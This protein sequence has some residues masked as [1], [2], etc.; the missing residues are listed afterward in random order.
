[1]LA[2]AVSWDMIDRNPFEKAESLQLTENN[3]RLSY[4]SEK[5]IR[6]LLLNARQRP[7]RQ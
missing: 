3:R 7:H 6:R 2:K 5:E 4:L 1:M